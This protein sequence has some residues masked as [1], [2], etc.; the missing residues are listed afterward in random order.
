MLVE[1]RRKNGRNKLTHKSH[2][3]MMITRSKLQDSVTISL[4][5]L[6]KSRI[7]NM[8]HPKNQKWD[9]RRIIAVFSSVS[10]VE[11]VN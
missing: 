9:F 6:K 8:I 10:K 4:K 5:S 11:Q 1:V 2:A 3:N 7:M